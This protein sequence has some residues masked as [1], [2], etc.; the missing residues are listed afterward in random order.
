MKKPVV[1]RKRADADIDA[2]ID[3][4]V[5]EAPHQVDRLISALET[6]LAV[7][8]RRPTTGSPGYSHWLSIPGLRH[9]RVGR[10]PYVVFYVEGPREISVLRVL[11]QGRDFAGALEPE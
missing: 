8:G 10:F 1:L 4:Y 2:A 5:V 9:R 11:H 7:I 6:T 3:F